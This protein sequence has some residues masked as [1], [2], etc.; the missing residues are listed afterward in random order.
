MEYLDIVDE[1]DNILGKA[2]K[3]EIYS[4]SM[5]HRIIHILIFNDKDELA[6][7]LRSSSVHFCPQHWSTAVGGH[8]QSGETYEEAAL[9]EY[10]EE[11]GI[12]SKLE[13][14]SKDLYQ[15]QG[16]PPKFLVT[17]KA[18]FNGPFSPDKNEVERVEF[19][20]MEHIKDMIKQGEKFHPELLYLLKKHIF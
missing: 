8:V 5:R 17:F 16:T 6:L 12:K 19:F 3:E 2:S 4:K 15:A 1:N 13:F 10:E 20:R 9:R 14:F 11:L 18:R 7:Q